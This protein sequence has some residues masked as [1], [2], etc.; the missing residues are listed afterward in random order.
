MERSILRIGM[1]CGSLVGTVAMSSSWYRFTSAHAAFSW[2][3]GYSNLSR[4]PRRAATA[5]SFAPTFHLLLLSSVRLPKASAVC[6]KIT[7]SILL[8]LYPWLL[9]S[10][11]TLARLDTHFD[12]TFSCDKP[13]MLVRLDNALVTSLS[14]LIFSL[15]DSKGTRQVHASGNLAMMASF[16]G[17]YDRFA[18][19]LETCSCA[20]GLSSLV[21]T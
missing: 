14:M 10:R 5:S 9:N 11:I 19:T 8:H 6:S 4:S 21:R 12:V 20:P 18:R 17:A 13:S 15:L 1:T 3:L 2:T 16:S 7:L